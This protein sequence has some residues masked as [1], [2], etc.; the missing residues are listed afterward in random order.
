MG[1]GIRERLKVFMFQL[2]DLYSGPVVVPFPF[3]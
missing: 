3:P 2:E 1:V